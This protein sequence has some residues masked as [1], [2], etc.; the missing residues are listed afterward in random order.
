MTIP[1]GPLPLP[2]T[3]DDLGPR[4]RK[5]IEQAAT[6]ALDRPEAMRLQVRCA[7]PDID[8]LD[9]DLSGTA[10]TAPPVRSHG[11]EDLQGSAGP[12]PEPQE[13]AEVAAASTPGRLRRLQVRAR[14]ME[15][16][17]ATVRIDAR[18]RDIRVAWEER[19]GSGSLVL[20]EPS[21]QSPLHGRVELGVSQAGL[22]TAI[23]R[24]G[25][26]LLEGR[27]ALDEVELEISG[28]APGALRVNG[29]GRIRWGL[30]RARVRIGAQ[31]DVQVDVQ[32]DV[33]EADAH[34]P[35][36]G[37]GPGSG[38]SGSGGALGGGQPV[39]L[40]T[41]SQVA[42]SSRHPVAAAML[43]RAA[44]DIRALEGRRVPLRSSDGAVAVTDLSV[45]TG[46]ELSVC[47]VLGGGPD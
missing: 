19:A 36:A 43:S 47:A 14:P 18:L 1:L 42:V 9:V 35:G 10:I 3:D 46:P 22:V 45:T 15:V 24:L 20:N 32:E 34:R 23:E 2:R 39:M 5:G 29:S 27:G 12:G 40:A 6:P 11:P 21:A 44:K 13:E 31:V 38:P 37:S 4:L 26:H 25:T 30:L 41:L 7:V 8:L 33:Q 28:A 16:L 17:G